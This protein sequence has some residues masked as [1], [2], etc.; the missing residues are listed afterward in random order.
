MRV[1]V[2]R[3]GAPN[4]EGGMAGAEV[5]GM[6]V[7]VARLGAPNLGGMGGGGG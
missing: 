7:R 5:G 3:L 4:L 1:R 6:R 2:A